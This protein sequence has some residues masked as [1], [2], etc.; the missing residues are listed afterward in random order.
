VVWL[1]TRDAGGPSGEITREQLDAFQAKRREL[2]AARAFAA[3]HNYNEAIRRYNAYLAKY[4]ESP[5]ALKEREEARRNLI[6]PLPTNQVITVSKA[7]PETTQPTK[8]PS[9][10]ERMK[11]WFRGH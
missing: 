7:R 1:R 5:V 11:R 8:P 4:P 9:R 3:A 2:D 6:L 10:W